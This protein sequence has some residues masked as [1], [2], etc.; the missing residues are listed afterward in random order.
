[1]VEE[2]VLKDLDKQILFKGIEEECQFVDS[3]SW[4]CKLIDGKLVCEAV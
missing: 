2:P 3:H 4:V 1:V